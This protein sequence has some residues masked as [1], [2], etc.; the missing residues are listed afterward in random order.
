M[1]DWA[2]EY[3]ERGYAQRWGLPPM[4]EKIRHETDGLWGC[5]QLTTGARVA[6]LGCGHGRHALALAARGADVVG[7]DSSV[8]LLDEARRSGLEP[9]LPARW[10]RGDM[11]AVPLR[12]GLCDAV[13]VL[14][15][16]GF[17]EGEEEHEQVLTEAAR[18]LRAGGHLAL[19]VVNGS[20]IL[21]DFRK[22][23]RQERDGVVVTVSRTLTRA[24]ARMIE[25]L[26]I[27]GARGEGK[28]ERRQRLYRVNEIWAAANR[29]GFAI[30]GTFADASGVAFDPETS[31]AMW[32][33]GQR[34]P[35]V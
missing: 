17:F 2:R 16:F 9:G 20:P 6:D 18:L 1:S 8:T 7:V 26:S 3:F 27:N 4:S 35:A 14:D 23:D 28:Y 15:A 11:R 29:A 19:K 32:V 13:M 24:P 12:S 22:A 5:L 25:H 30:V 21:A 34:A 33:I 10:V 31:L